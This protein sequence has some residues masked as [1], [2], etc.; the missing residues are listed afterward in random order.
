MLNSKFQK[1]DLNNKVNTFIVEYEKA[2]KRS[3]FLTDIG[4]F[5]FPRKLRDFIESKAVYAELRWPEVYN[6]DEGF[7]GN[8]FTT[9]EDLTWERFDKLNPFY[10][11][12]ELPGDV[13]QQ[14]LYRIIER[15]GNRT[16]PRRG[17]LFSQDFGLDLNIPVSYSIDWC[18]PHLYDFLKPLIPQLNLDTI[19]PTNYFER[20]SNNLKNINEIKLE[21]ILSRLSINKL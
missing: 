21:E 9:Q 12:K 15:D 11:T 13:N 7:I 19:C 3:K 18:D 20:N 16:G 5:Y 8:K 4:E 2:I 14:V 17:V 10:I 6:D 1:Y